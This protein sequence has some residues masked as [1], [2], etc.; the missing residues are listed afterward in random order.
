MK[1]LFKPKELIGTGVQLMIFAL[2]IPFISI[3]LGLMMESAPDA[4]DKFASAVLSFLPYSDP[5]Q[6][7]VTGIDISRPGIGFLTYTAALMNTIG[8]NVVAAMYIG[9]WLYAFR[10]IFREVL[11]D[12][13]HLHGLPILQV[14]CGLFFGAMTFTML[15]DEVMGIVATLF[16]F[17]LD[18]VL[19]IVFV[20]KSPWK[21]ILDLAINLSLQSYLAALTIGYVAVIA[22]C[23]QGLYATVAHAVTMLVMVTLL[24][25][26]YL[27]AQYLILEK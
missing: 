13:L 26:V 2:L 10:M 7:I 8:S 25:I 1:K 9:M 21:K 5:I 24:W 12:I 16:L 17:V 15:E 4:K 23:V 11:G 3:L 6:N 14:V 20:R 18:I 19:T 22:S 27:V